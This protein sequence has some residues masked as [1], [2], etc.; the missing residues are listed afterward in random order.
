MLK[1]QGLNTHYGAIHALKGIDLEIHKGEV[2]TVRE[3]VPC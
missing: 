2:V 1:I 3:R